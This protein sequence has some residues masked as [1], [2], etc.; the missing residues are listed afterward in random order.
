VGALRR[1]RALLPQDIPWVVAAIGFVVL[2]S[3]N[4]AVQRRQTHKREVT[5]ERIL[6]VQQALE[7]YAIDNAGRFPPQKVG[8]SALVEPPGP[9]VQPQPLR[10][11]GP[12]VTSQEDL[13]DGWGRPFWYLVGGP[14][15]P[16]RPYELFS[17]GADNSDGGKS[18]DADI[19]AWDPDTLVP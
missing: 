2:V 8:L 13:R 18:M 6:K 16:P 15:D 3:A 11:C 12:Y 19:D 17:Q 9:D 7:R 10:W 1:R 14:G 4:T 5:I